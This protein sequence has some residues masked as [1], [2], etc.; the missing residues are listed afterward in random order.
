MNIPSKSVG[1][2][3]RTNTFTFFNAL[4]LFLAAAVFLT[5]EYHNMLFLGVIFANTAIGITQE[6]R[7]KRVIDRLSL[8]NQTKARVLRNNIAAEINISEIV[9]G[10]IIILDEGRQIPAD[11]EVVSGEIEVDESLITG[12]S[13]P[14]GKKAGSSLLSG[15][16]VICGLAHAAV[17][18][19]GADS[20]AFSIMKE[21]KYLK[22]PV[23]KMLAAINRIIKYLA[24]IILPIG[25]TLTII[26]VFFTGEDI[27]D[28]INS[29]VAA[30]LGMIPQGLI[31]LVSVV[32][33]VSV[34]RL[35][36]H[37]ALARDMYCAETLARVDVL[38]LDKTGTITTGE[39][40]VEELIPLN[41]ADLSEI[42]T[43]LCAL[44]Q[45]LPDKNPTA[46]AVRKKFSAHPNREAVTITSFSSARKWSGATFK[47]H[48]SYVLSAPDV[49]NIS[50]SDSRRVLILAKSP[51]AINNNNLP[52]SLKPI[53][54]LI[55][56]DTVRPEA[57]KTLE[58]FNKQGVEIKII[59][60]DNPLTVKNAAVAAGVKNAEKFID[61]SNFD[62]ENVDNYVEIVENYTI[63]G[64]VN[65]QNKLKLIKALKKNHTVGMVGD[66]V[67]DVLPLKEADFSAAMY[68]GSEAARNVSSLILLDNNFSSLP[69]AVAEGRRS[70]NNLERSAA[71]FL[72]KTIYTLIIAVVYLFLAAPFPFIPIQ[73]SLINGLFI[74]LPSFFLALEKNNNL[75]HGSFVKNVFIKAVPYGL[76]AAIGLLALSFFARFLDFT[77]EETRTSATI[78]LGIASFAILCRLCI[79]FNKKRLF[80]V[81][82]SGILFSL[83]VRYLDD[84][85]DVTEFTPQMHV[86]TLV[87]CLAMI[88][89]SVVLPKAAKRIGLL[90]VK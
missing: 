63:F 15:S 64:R 49:L 88:P 62:N 82:F 80:L 29:S 19:T 67:N 23:S 11:C 48:G 86:V 24:V 41:N 14:V 46:L 50:V 10:D 33:A 53:A 35:S 32:M 55:I 16:F 76:C 69:K 87:I 43:A 36:R 81:A 90:S 34:I 78:I 45:V 66:G 57:G 47:T 20:F 61:L 40:T 42:Q 54:K 17:I 13:E 37:N 60:G 71:L 52:P 68:S 8:I 44:M 65:P 9:Q 70:I 30:I 77:Y 89:L 12:E 84:L 39:M 72:T 73:M 21:A 56:N 28:A 59:S 25:I 27:N 3:I 79:P 58:Y 18:K 31:L 26:S 5:G 51:F 4:N 1:E 75:V 74:G 83:A 2:I 38:C 85:L 22:K 7:A 6:L